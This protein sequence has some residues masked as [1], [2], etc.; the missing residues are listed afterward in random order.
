MS[1]PIVY[2]DRS[3]VRPARAA[4]LKA[5]MAELVEFVADREPQLLSYGFFLDEDDTQM[6]VVA[7]HPDSASIE[8]HMEVGGPKFRE[9]AD[10]IDLQGIEVYGEPSERVRELLRQKAQ[11]LGEAGSVQVHS[12]Q[13][14]FSRLAAHAT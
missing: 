7:V 1:E 12:R 8:L 6:T 3:T 9:F 2:I 13:A 4:E 10:L 14:G 5:A 11:L